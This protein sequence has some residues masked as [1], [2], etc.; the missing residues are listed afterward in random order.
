MSSSLTMFGRAFALGALVAPDDYVAIAN[1]EIALCRTV[2]PSNASAAQLIEPVA[3]AYA[4]QTYPTGSLYWA[5]SGFGEF[6]NTTL[7]TWP[8]VEA[9]EWGLIRGYAIIDPVSTQCV[10][11]GTIKNP[12]RATV[13]YV[14]KMEPG[15]VMLAIYD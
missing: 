14:P 13:G 8:Q 12:F 5:P 6:Y 3:T 7:I 4:R 1:F 11:T 15:S 10:Q 9:E 2:P